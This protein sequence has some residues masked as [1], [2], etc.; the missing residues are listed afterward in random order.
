MHKYELDFCVALSHRV[1][2]SE[3]GRIDMTPQ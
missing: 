3:L 1:F 2:T